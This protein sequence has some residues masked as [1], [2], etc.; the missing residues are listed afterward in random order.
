[1][2]I[3]G[4]PAY[5]RDIAAALR[6]DAGAIDQAAD[7]TRR[8]HGVDWHGPAA[9]RFRDRVTDH[10]REITRTREAVLAAARSV[11]ALADDL[12]ERQRLIEAARRAVLNAVRN[13]E[14]AVERVGEYAWN[15]LTQAEADGYR[16]ARTLLDRTAELPSRGAPEWLDLARTLGR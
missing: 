7:R 2:T 9:E 1:M 12:E 3:G 15:T 4:D 5:L 13:A 14:R 16:A 11:D 8:L 6:Q 10:V